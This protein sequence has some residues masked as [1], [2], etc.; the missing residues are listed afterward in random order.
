MQISLQPL[1]G[2]SNFDLCLQTVGSI[3]GFISFLNSN[4]I[5]LSSVPPTNQVVYN[6]NGVLSSGIAGNVYSTYS[7]NQTL[8]PILNNDGTPL[9]DNNGQPIYNN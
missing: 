6:T 7:Y 8:Q 5:G 1:I 9:L 4:K 3:N 2:Q